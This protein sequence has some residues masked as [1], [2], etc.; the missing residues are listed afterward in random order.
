MTRGTCI[1]YHRPPGER[2]MA[3]LCVCPYIFPAQW[4]CWEHSLQLSITPR[5]HLHNDVE[6]FNV[7][8]KG[9]SGG[10]LSEGNSEQESKHHWCKQI[11]SLK[12]LFRAFSFVRKFKWVVNRRHASKKEFSTRVASAQSLSPHHHSPSRPERAGH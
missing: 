10:A 2:K 8:L 7:H 3:R 5:K 1:C 12:N 6:I 9:S 4:Q 11:L